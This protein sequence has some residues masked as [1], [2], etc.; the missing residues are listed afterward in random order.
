MAGFFIFDLD[1][2][3]A[4][5][6]HRVPLIESEGWDA[7][8]AACYKD[9]P[10]K[11]VINTMIELWIADNRIE[12]WSGRDDAVKDM[13]INW[14]QKH[15]SDKDGNLLWEE[16]GIELKMRPHGDFT[17]DDELKKQWLDE[18]TAQE[19]ARL[20]AV[21]DDRD[22]VVQMWRENGVCC[23]QVAPGAF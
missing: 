8:F 16:M 14:L 12:I 5:N 15:V 6:E 11:P 4:L 20:T 22:K 3:L 10:N 13:T 7:F 21:F 2:T 19:R 23:A 17:P 18:L 1:G 9:E